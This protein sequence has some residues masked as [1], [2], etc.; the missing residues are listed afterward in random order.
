MP[1]FID[2]HCHLHSRAYEQERAVIGEDMER[3]GV[4]AVTVGT[5][6]A[7][8]RQAIQYAEE[9]AG[10]WA[11]VGYHPEHFSSDFHD[12]DE[13]DAGAYS[14]EELERTARSSSRVVAIGETGLDFYR[15]DEGRDRQESQAAQEAGFREQLGLAH[16]LGLPIVIHC[17]EALDRLAKIIQDERSRGISVRAV[18]HCYTGTWAEAEPLL[19]LGACLSF[20]GIITFPSK[21]SEDPDRHVHRV[22]ERMSLDRIMIETDAPWLAPVPHRGQRNR[23]SYVRLVAERV[24]ALRGLELDEVAAQ[25]TANARN[26]F[27]I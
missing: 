18:V 8:S 16:R 19:D 1:K 7:T 5:T 4:W 23:P 11:T 6:I 15:I 25:T 22:I 12:E 26:F 21:K 13:G 24:A 3:E 9:H 20:T 2:S 17:R 27:G 10:V 14:L